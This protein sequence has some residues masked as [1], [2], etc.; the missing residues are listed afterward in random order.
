M[1]PPI[2]L[3][4]QYP[5]YIRRRFLPLCTFFLLRHLNLHISP[6]VPVELLQM[7]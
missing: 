6:I 7:L 2:L 4:L 1:M 3:T 5:R